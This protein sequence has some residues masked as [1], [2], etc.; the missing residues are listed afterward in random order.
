[1]L[2]AESGSAARRQ[3]VIAFGVSAVTNRNQLGEDFFPVSGCGDD[4]E[5]I[6]AQRSADGLSPSVS[7]QSSVRPS[8]M[9][10]SIR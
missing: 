7:R 1:M 3:T 6:G 9:T 2:K 10:D 4:D 8:L 5:R